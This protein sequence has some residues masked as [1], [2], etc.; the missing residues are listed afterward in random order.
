MEGKNDDE[1][2]KGK[3]EERTRSKKTKRKSALKEKPEKNGFQS[4]L[5]QSTIDDRD[6]VTTSPDSAKLD[7][8]K[9]SP[10]KPKKKRIRNSK[11][12]ENRRKGSRSGESDRKSKT[13]DISTI[14]ISELGTSSDSG[15][16]TDD[17]SEAY[18]EIAG[19]PSVR[20]MPCYFT[21]LNIILEINWCSNWKERLQYKK[22]PG[23]V[24]MQN[25]CKKLSSRLC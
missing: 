2:S 24:Q 7:E 23:R 9:N 22:T 4:R 19:F 20:F 3:N 25:Y 12:Q 11:K 13:P 8:S 16:H 18:V 14:E 5:Q 21:L 10:K 6:S 15:T 1:S 17:L